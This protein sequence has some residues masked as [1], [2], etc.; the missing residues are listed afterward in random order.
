MLSEVGFIKN[1]IPYFS[2]KQ[3]MKLW[4]ASFIEDKELADK[5]FELN[6]TY[7]NSLLERFTRKFILNFSQ[8]AD[9]T[10]LGAPPL[11]DIA[12]HLKS[13]DKNIDNITSGFKKLKI[14]TYDLNDR[15]KEEEQMLKTFNEFKKSKDK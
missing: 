1:G 10:R 7:S 8:F 11:F 13:I 4:A 14:E 12:E 3:S 6:V 15:N 9:L 5:S 2:P